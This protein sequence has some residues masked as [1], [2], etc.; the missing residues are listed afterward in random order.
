MA[1]TWRG[2]GGGRGRGRGRGRGGRHAGGRNGNNGNDIDAAGGH[3]TRSPRVLHGPTPHPWL[4]RRL[5]ITRISHKGQRR[6]VNAVIVF[7]DPAESHPFHVLHDDGAHAW[8]AIQESQGVVH[9]VEGDSGGTTVGVRRKRISRK[10]VWLTQVLRR[11]TV[12][13]ERGGAGGAP[14][15]NGSHGNPN[16]NS[17]ALPAHPAPAPPNPTTSMFFNPNVPPLGASTGRF[18]RK[19]VGGMYGFP[20]SP[21]P[22][23]M[24]DPHRRGR[25]GMN[26]NVQSSMQADLARRASFSS[27]PGGASGV[28]LSPLGQLLAGHP[29][30]ATRV[31]NTT[32]AHAVHATHDSPI[33]TLNTHGGFP[34][35]SPWDGILE[36]FG[37]EAEDVSGDGGNAD[38]RSLEAAARVIGAAAAN[39][40]PTTSG[41]NAHT[42]THSYAQQS[43]DGM[44]K[45]VLQTLVDDSIALLKPAALALCVSAA[46]ERRYPPNRRKEMKTSTLGTVPTTLTLKTDTPS[47]CLPLR[48]ACAGCSISLAGAFAWRA[49]AACGEAVCVDC[50]RERRDALANELEKSNT[51]E[52]TGR[53][54]SADTFVFLCVA[55]PECLAS[56]T[57]ATRR[58]GLRTVS[59]QNNFE[60]YANLEVDYSVDFVTVKALRKSKGFAAV[61]AVESG[62]NTSNIG[63][64]PSPVSNE[65]LRLSTLASPSDFLSIAPAC[66]R[67]GESLQ[68]FLSEAKWG[69]DGLTEGGNAVAPLLRLVW[70]TST[71]AV[72]RELNLFAE[73][74][75][76]DVG[77]TREGENN[78]TGKKRKVSHD[79]EDDEVPQDDDSDPD[80]PDDSNAEESD[81]FL[82]LLFATTRLPCGI[83]SGD[84]A[85]DAADAS[86]AARETRRY[87]LFFF[88]LIILPAF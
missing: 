2:S 37:T 19:P 33:R 56:A 41:L 70:N 12:S 1:R 80:S 10:F 9:A 78:S 48:V 69:A 84:L 38:L 28:P 51:S 25:F 35:A 64:T 82:G 31:S 73:R 30:H 11:E 16:A 74:A 83:A 36:E 76:E 43:L 42:D 5:R 45:S 14:R 47:D 7:H 62:Y 17:N 26:L 77:R 67:E 23:L 72:V 60:N 53:Q 63:G 66:V 65:N 57:A 81:G 79:G 20:P 55:T 85:A 24:F 46:R 22:S 40:T 39:N 6:Y 75:K 27:F 3:S 68:K 15:V 50:C 8:L 52:D 58:A 13:N 87:I 86:D 49:C 59:D 71:G 61:S 18:I 4:G 44:D 54:S 88:P 29:V 32:N 34:K 21:L